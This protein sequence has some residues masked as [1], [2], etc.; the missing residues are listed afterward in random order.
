MSGWGGNTNTLL[1]SADLG[2]W[3]A[4]RLVISSVRVTGELIMAEGRQGP[5]AQQ[6]SCLS[7]WLLAIQSAQPAL[8]H[9]HP[10]HLQTQP[11]PWCE[12][13][14]KLITWARWAFSFGEGPH[15]PSLY[16][17]SHQA[18]R[19]AVLPGPPAQ[20][21][22]WVPAGQG[23]GSAHRV[24]TAPSRHPWGALRP[25]VSA[26]ARG[27]GWRLP[28]HHRVPGPAP[29]TPC[30]ILPL[31]QVSTGMGVTFLGGQLEFFQLLLSSLPFLRAAQQ[32]SARRSTRQVR[33]NCTTNA[34][35]NRCHCQQPTA[36]RPTQQ[37][38]CLGLPRALGRRDVL[39]HAAWGSR[40]AAARGCA[41]AGAVCRSEG[42]AAPLSCCS[43]R[44]RLEGKWVTRMAVSL[45]SL[46]GIASNRGIG[47]FVF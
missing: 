13:V 11:G 15:T 33:S 38:P 27:G 25:W 18:R 17:V 5:N 10:K 45:V 12:V 14:F 31:R 47:G 37:P 19:A 39:R 41:L 32:P 16:M 29:R 36:S 43:C 40:S 7:E 8:P 20:R 42:S 30:R 44:C 1:A 24:P 35:W 4:V 34:S 23:H 21:W 2:A 46:T 9:S 26:A 6:G 3:I 22:L 28:A